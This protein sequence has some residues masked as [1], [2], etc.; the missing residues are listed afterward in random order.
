[1]GFV[2]FHVPRILPSSQMTPGINRVGHAA[3]ACA[4]FGGKQKLAG[5][6]AFRVRLGWVLPGSRDERRKDPLDSMLRSWRAARLAGAC[7]PGVAEPKIRL[8]VATPGRCYARMPSDINDAKLRP[9]PPI[10]VQK[11]CL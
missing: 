7:G 6:R 11:R 3:R 2:L 10:N 4:R 9:K 1:M 5:K 8:I